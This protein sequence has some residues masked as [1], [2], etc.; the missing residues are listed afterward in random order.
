MIESQ[1]I[2]FLR[3]KQTKAGNNHPVLLN[4]SALLAD[5]DMHDL[6]VFEH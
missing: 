6:Q 5:N 2:Q 4:K 3:H 1:E